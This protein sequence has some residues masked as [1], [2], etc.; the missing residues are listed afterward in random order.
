MKNLKVANGVNPG[1]GL[2]VF[3]VAA[4]HG[5]VRAGRLVGFGLFLDKAD[6]EGK[7]RLRRRYQTLFSSSW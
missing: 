3:F 6:D 5:P 2:A 1:L 7:R 4:F